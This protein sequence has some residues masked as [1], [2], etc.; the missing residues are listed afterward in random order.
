MTIKTNVNAK[1]T[2]IQGTEQVW[3][4]YII[5][6]IVLL[7]QFSACCMSLRYSYGTM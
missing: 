3:T 7:C 2:K 1:K 5:D 4:Q 6:I